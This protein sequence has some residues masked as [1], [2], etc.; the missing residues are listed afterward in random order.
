MVGWSAYTEGAK[1]QGRPVETLAGR[2]APG[3]QYALDRQE[4]YLGSV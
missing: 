3:P 1:K 4:F 2:D